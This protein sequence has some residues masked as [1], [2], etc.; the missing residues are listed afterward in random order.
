VC[1]RG[2]SVCVRVQL[3][4][5]VDDVNDN[6]PRFTSASEVTVFEDSAVG[7]A[8]FQL[9]ATDADLDD[10]ARLTYSVVD[11]SS[12]FNVSSTDGVV[13]TRRPLDRETK[14]HSCLFNSPLHTL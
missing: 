2:L 4:I 6:W 1:E 5:M 14:V 8:V 13:R 11:S 12:T 3:T 7:S 10:A 9:A